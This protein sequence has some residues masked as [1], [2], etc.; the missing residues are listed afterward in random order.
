MSQ[1]KLTLELDNVNNPPSHYVGIGASA[2]GL[3]AIDT[4]FKNMPS[5]SGCAF[6]VVQHL[7][8]DHKSLMAELLSKRTKMPVRRAEEGVVVQANHVYLIPPSHDLR[9]FHGKLLLTEQKRDGGINLPI[10]IFLASLAEDQGDK[11]VAIIL[12]GTGSD[13]TRGVRA[14]KE[15]VGMVMVQDE[16]TAGFDGMPRSAIATGLVDYIIPPDEMPNQLISYIQHPYVNKTKRSETLLSDEDGINRIF[17]MLREKTGVDFT[18]YKP[19]T[20]VRRIERRMSVNQL[21]MLRDYVDYLERYPAEID[22]LHRDLLIGVTSFF[23]DPKVFKHLQEEWLPELIKNSETKKIRIWVSA[24]S[25]GEEAYTLAMI[26]HEVMSQM[27]QLA[28]IKIFAT[29]V[30]KDAI[31]TAGMGAYPES[32]TADVPPEF[33]SR[34]FHR[35]ENDFVIARHIREMV[36][37]AQHNVIKDPPFTNIELVSC[38]NMLIYLQPVLQQRVMELFN[39]S[40]NPNG[41]LL[42]GTSETTGEMS[43]YFEPLHHKW[44]IYRS[45]G[46]KRRDALSEPALTYNA[47]GKLTQPMGYSINRA[48]KIPPQEDE[49]LLERLLQKATERYLP[50]TMV[51]NERLELLHMVGNASEYLQFPTGR[52]L[53]DV[54]KLA[55][56]DLAIPLSTGIQKVLK[57]QEDVD[58]SNIHIRNE[59]GTTVHVDMRVSLLQGSKS[60]APLVSVFIEQRAKSD[61]ASTSKTTYTYD[62]GKEAEQRIS[63][64]EQELQFTRESLQATV[65]ELETSNEELQATNEELLASN[66]ELQSTNEELQSVNEELYTVNAEHQ[67]KISELIDVN[68]D[69]DNLLNNIHIA[70]LFLDQ[71]LDIRRYTPEISHFIRIIEQD[72]GR[73][74]D[75]LAHELVGVDLDD[76]VKRANENNESIEKE[77]KDRNDNTYLMRVRPYRIGPDIFSG[78]LLTFINV[79]SAKKAQKALM[80][81]EERNKL[82][83]EAANFG[84][85]DW[86]I[87]TNQMVLSETIE[88]ILGLDKGEF[89][90]TYD[91][92]LQFIHRDDRYQVEKAV[93]ES[94]DN[95]QIPFQIKH[96]IVTPKKITRWVQEHGRVHVDGDELPTRMVGIIKDITD[97]IEA[98][99][100]LS[101]SKALY[102]STLESLEMIAVQ[103]DGKGKAIF[104]NEYFFEVSGWNS[105]DVIGK[106]WIDICIPEGEREEAKKVFKGFVKNSGKMPHISNYENHLSCKNGEKKL[107]YWSYTPVYDRHGNRVGVSSIGQILE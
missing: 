60:Q 96:R 66:E 76:F 26:C 55:K 104:A 38:R 56:R 25:T 6:I 43:D 27:G 90:G 44:K 75:H 64:L 37:F 45:R 57:S 98:E 84:N 79:N 24:C 35:R 22:T 99:E 9:I 42:L 21:V 72:I 11:S 16:D 2:G 103:L 1:S 54:S 53:T 101:R 46:K 83:Q 28:E 81:S 68:N 20:M 63:D 58:Y 29:D 80:L 30:D 5:D 52:M 70:T 51:V 102:F 23:R 95:P 41:L 15:K 77:V 33:L 14:I 65:E 74:F 67:S 88:G 39:F 31:A 78:V 97:E 49:R 94:L 3:E 85:W 92:F 87:E 61:K 89:D 86:D 8:P 12:S 34:Y 93:Q 18:Y 48:N 19:S 82:S 62:V 32:I 69:L 36:V 91:S 50:F 73:P 71:N 107:I 7:S 59:D 105:D 13:G 10:D 17:L 100:A 47:S 4:F 106:S 40:L